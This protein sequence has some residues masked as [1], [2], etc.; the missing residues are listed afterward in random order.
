MRSNVKDE[1]KDRFKGWSYRNWV[2]LPF[3]VES[4]LE[5]SSYW[6]LWWPILTFLKSVHKR[7]IFNISTWTVNSLNRPW[8][9]KWVFLKVPYFG[10]WW[11]FQWR[12][13]IIGRLLQ[14]ANSSLI[15]QHNQRKLS[16]NASIQ[17]HNFGNFCK[18]LNLII[19]RVNYIRLIDQFREGFCQNKQIHNR[20][21]HEKL[22]FREGLCKNKFIFGFR[23][24]GFWKAYEAMT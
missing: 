21:K 6:L 9:K 15:T 23:I 13:S 3:R 12:E 22:G 5:L 19:K 20:S 14:K 16:N 10:Q 1:E 2:D 17:T 4:D 24:I 11:L 7:L 8:I 18:D